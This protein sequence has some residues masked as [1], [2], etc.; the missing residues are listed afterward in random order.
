MNTY[1]FSAF[2]S[3]C[4]FSFVVYICIEIEIYAHLESHEEHT[5]L[6]KDASSY[7]LEEF[8]YRFLSCNGYI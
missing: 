5:K 1:L 7:L 6:V 8:T 2:I 4:I 3:F